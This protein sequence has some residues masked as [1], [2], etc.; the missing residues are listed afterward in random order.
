MIWKSKN[1]IKLKSQI[2][3]HVWKTWMT[4]KKND[5]D[6]DV[7]INRNCES[8]VKINLSL[9]LTKYNALKTYPLIN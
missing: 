2:G 6:D 3:L 9:W 4:M 1:S 7:D 5:D 8:K